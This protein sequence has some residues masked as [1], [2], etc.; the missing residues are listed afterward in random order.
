MSS[1]NE[2]QRSIVDVE[3]SVHVGNPF[4]DFFDVGELAS[5]SIVGASNL[6]RVE[7]FA[8]GDGGAVV[9]TVKNREEGKSEV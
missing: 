6:L 3:D 1:T 4:R 2:T 5:D 9:R 8:E 7:V